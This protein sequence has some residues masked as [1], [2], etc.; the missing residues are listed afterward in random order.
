MRQIGEKR[1]FSLRVDVSGNDELPMLASDINRML[2]AL[3]QSQQAISQKNQ[4][5]SGYIRQVEQVIEAATA[6]ETNTF[7]PEQL[8]GVAA[9]SDKL[10]QLAQVFTRMVRTVTTREQELAEAKE[11]LE[12]VLD[13]VPGTISWINSSG[14]YLGVNRRLAEAWNLTQDAFI[15]KEIGFHKDGSQ[16]VDFM[17]QFLVSEEKSAAQAIAV[18]LKGAVKYYLVAAQKYQNR[19]A[20]VTVGIDITER[21]QAEEA[22]RLAEA[23]YRG[24]FEH[25][26]E[27]IFRSPPD[28]QYIEVNPA[29]TALFGYESPESMT[30]QIADLSQQI[31]AEQGDHDTFKQL[32]AEQDEIKD[33]E[34]QAYRRDG[35]LFWVL[36]WARAVR[37]AQG[38]LLYYEG[39]CV[40]VTKRKQEEAVLKQQLQELKIEIDQTKRAREVAAITET[41]YFQQLLEEA[42]SLRF[43][44]GVA[45]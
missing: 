17:R 32:M 43:N 15:G 42:D 8:N 5:M 22:L 34:Y 25:A 39:S 36:E 18:P 1:N 40:D 44:E 16:F 12:A 4:E 9:R 11:Q 20:T 26:V 35:S 38:N 3:E 27:G 37:D 23:K 28:G 13:A 41:D 19:T 14:V 24:I 30:Q 6:V 29:M 10:G 7:K 31:Y 33:F 45:E 2:V 21:K